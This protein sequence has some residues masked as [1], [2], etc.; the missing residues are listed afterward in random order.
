M[1]QK[2]L[3][4]FENGNVWMNPHQ[5]SCIP[6]SRFCENLLPGLAGGPY[7]S[8]NKEPIFLSPFSHYMQYLFLVPLDQTC[9]APLCL[10]YTLNYFISY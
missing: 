9:D 5:P 2:Y 4:L 3:T 10:M 7:A 6:V 8:Y 1:E